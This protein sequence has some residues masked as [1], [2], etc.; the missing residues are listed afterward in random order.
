MASPSFACGHD[1]KRNNP[2]DPILTPAVELEVALDD[3]ATL[4]WTPYDGNSNRDGDFEIYIMNAD[5]SN[6]VNL[7]NNSAHADTDADWSPDGTQIVFISSRDTEWPDADIY[8]MD[9]DGSNVT[10]LTTGPHFDRWP[11]WRPVGK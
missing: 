3:T 9:A 5:G 6:Q 10:R 1:S 2:L 4:T 8:V 7:T 11:S